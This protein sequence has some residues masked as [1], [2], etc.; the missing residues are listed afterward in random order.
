MAAPGL[1]V[2]DRD[3]ARVF[4]AL[5]PGTEPVRISSGPLPAGSAIP[6]GPR[7]PA[8]PDFFVAIAAAINDSGVIQIYGD[9]PDTGTDVRALVGWLGVR[10]PEIAARVVSAQVIPERFW[11][12]NRL[13]TQARNYLMNQTSA[14]SAG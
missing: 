1:I 3:E 4:R 14:L 7:I 10:N 13:L 11:S 8:S 6:F 9:G 2:I 12:N 5:R